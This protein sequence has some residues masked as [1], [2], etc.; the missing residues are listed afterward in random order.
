[1]PQVHAAG[2]V[3]GSEGGVA[4]EAESGEQRLGEHERVLA[5]VGP[6]SQRA[7]S[8]QLRIDRSVMVGV[9]GGLERAGH[10][11]RERDAGDR[12]AYAVTITESPRRLLAL[13]EATVPHISTTPS[14]P[15]HQ[16]N[17]SNSPYCSASSC[18]STP[19]VRPRRQGGRPGRG[20]GR[21]VRR[22]ASGVRRQASGVRRQA[23]GVRRQAI[24]PF[25]QASSCIAVRAR[26]TRT[27]ATAAPTTAA[28]ATSRGVTFP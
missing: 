15:S 8:D 19:D 3:L 2:D 17:A 4:P 24:M 18:D 10:V 21:G 5:A 26:T 16:A 22:Q 11:R 1:M 27:A 12:R 13:A 28:S 14:K 25:V 23:S 9:C 20:S 7:L 6:G